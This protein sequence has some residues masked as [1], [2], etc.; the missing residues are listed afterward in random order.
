MVAFAIF[1]SEEFFI[2]PAKELF[3]MHLVLSG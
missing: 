1:L 2:F 3:S